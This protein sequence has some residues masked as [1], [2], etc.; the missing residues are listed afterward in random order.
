MEKKDILHTLTT[1]EEEGEEAGERERGGKQIIR[2]RFCHSNTEFYVHYLLSFSQRS[3]YT[4]KIQKHEN[5]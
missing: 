5:E 3:S 4:Q 2:I 1:Q